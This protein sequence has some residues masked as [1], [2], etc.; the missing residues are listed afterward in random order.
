M[1][2]LTCIFACFALAAFTSTGPRSVLAAGPDDDPPSI[3]LT[4]A[5][6]GQ[7]FTSC[8]YVV[9]A[10]PAQSVLLVR[11]P[12]FASHSSR[13]LL[14][15]VAPDRFSLAETTL[16]DLVATSVDELLSSSGGRVDVDFLSCLDAAPGMLALRQ[17]APDVLMLQLSGMT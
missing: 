13:V 14:V 4:R 12:G 6:V 17:A 10:G 8:G 11:N 16:R 7:Q 3:A 15:S 9:S 5:E 1:R 2:L